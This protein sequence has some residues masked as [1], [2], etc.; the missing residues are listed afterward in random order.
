MS[1]LLSLPYGHPDQGYNLPDLS[2]R[3]GTG[4]L[5]PEEEAAHEARDAEQ[6]ADTEATAQYEH[7]LATAIRD[8]RLDHAKLRFTSMDPT[9]VGLS[10]LPI[11]LHVFGS[12]FTMSTKILFNG[13]EEPI[14]FI[15]ENEITTI[16]TPIFVVPASVPVGVREIGVGIEAEGEE[17]GWFTFVQDQ[18]PE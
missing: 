1:D 10:Q 18:L 13:Q 8:D 12:G 6:V 15:S 16:I 2:F 14:T 4:I 7:D 3:D 17:T 11:E 9:W 5:P